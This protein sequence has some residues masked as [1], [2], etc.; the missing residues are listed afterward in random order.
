M[1]PLLFVP[2]SYPD[3]LFGS[4][5]ARIRLHNGPIAW[6][7][8]LENSGVPSVRPRSLGIAHI[9][10]QTLHIATVISFDYVLRVRNAD[11]HF[12]CRA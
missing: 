8:F 7:E 12:Y 1:T 9:N 11:A 5:L 10:C 2:A 6:R 3:E 4:W